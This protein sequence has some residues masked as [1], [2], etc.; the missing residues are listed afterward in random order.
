MEMV[1][2]FSTLLLCV[3]G[4]GQTAP[5]APRTGR[6]DGRALST[7]GEAVEKTTVILSR[8]SVP[9]GVPSP[10]NLMF[11]PRAEAVAFETGADGVFSFADLTP[12]SYMLRAERRGYATLTRARTFTVQPGQTISDVVFK[13]TP[14]AVISGRIL[15]ADGDPL[16]NA[17]VSALRETYNRNGRQ[18]TTIRSAR[19]DSQGSFRISGLPPGRF[20][21]SAG[22]RNYGITTYYPGSL[23]LLGA[24]AIAAGAGSELSGMDIRVLRDGPHRFTIR[25]KAVMTTG[26]SVA[27]GQS[28]TVKTLD[29]QGGG[30]PASGVRD[31]GSFEI[32][33][34]LPG[35]Y[36]IQTL[37]AF[38]GSGGTVTTAWTDKGQVEVTITDRDVDDVVL[39]VQPAMKVAGVVRIDDGGGNLH[40]QPMVTL[41][42]HTVAF[43]GASPV[44]QV[45]EDG[46]FEIG[47]LGPVLYDAQLRGLPEHTFVRS[48]RFAGHDVTHAPIDLEAGSA[49]KIEIVL[50]GGAPSVAGTVKPD[51]VVALWNTDEA[52]SVTADGQGAFRFD[53]LAPGEYRILAWQGIEDGLAEWAPF[54]DAFENQST[55]LNLAEGAQVT[56]QIPIVS[57]EAAESELRRLP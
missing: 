34:L 28:L 17:G 4:F 19:T 36:I 11:P 1:R 23:D 44:A 37:D 5:Q 3:C 8:V 7:T 53:N 32:K 55:R 41:A 10:G 57:R 33:D 22:A 25:G 15:D 26:G 20:I 12:G 43:N 27:H 6:I 56:P 2:I 46:S 50:S 35:T 39:P 29:G 13:M 16:E 45:R 47:G 18:W 38:T 52:H 54:C 14:Q 49:G 40:A 48:I 24:S 42:A 30:G 9:S 21:L 31:D 51:A